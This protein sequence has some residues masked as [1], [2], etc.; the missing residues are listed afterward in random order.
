[1]SNEII[2]CKNCLRAINGKFC[3]HCGEKIVEAQ[4][5]TLAHIFRETFGAITNFDSRF[6]KTFKTLFLRPGQLTTNFIEGVR[7]PYVKPFQVFLIANI[8]FFLFLSDLDV[9]RTPSKWYFTH[10]NDEFGVM[11][12][13][14][15]IQEERSISFEEVAL[16]YD[17]L[18][19]GLAKGLIFLLIP[20]IAI[21][22]WVLNFKSRLPIGQHFI[23]A[24]HYFAFVLLISVIWTQVMDLVLTAH[25]RWYYIIPINIFMFGH[26]II[27]QRRFYKN[28]WVGAI[29]KGIV[30]VFFTGFFIQMYRITI[31]IVSLN[32]I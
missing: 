28:S 20:F 22:G 13:V 7:I 26:Y 15:E 11:S 4:D 17:N 24:I 29:I 10:D 5:F 16:L 32:W 2:K 1:M 23:F 19:S 9:F 21:I 14:S 6:Y 8:I 30:G 18:S 3:A 25:N 27:G 12:K 31:N